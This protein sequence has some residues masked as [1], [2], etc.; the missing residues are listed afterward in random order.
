MSKTWVFIDYRP[1]PG[2]RSHGRVADEAVV[3]YIAPRGMALQAAQEAVIQL[4]LARVRIYPLS[5]A[6]RHWGPELAAYKETH[7]SLAP[8]GRS[9]NYA[10]FSARQHEATAQAMAALCVALQAL[11]APLGED[12][13]PRARRIGDD[14]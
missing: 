4:N 8:L 14:A 11:P 7:P 3:L 5:L 13:A 10:E 12:E 2:W 9:R 1:G 6:R